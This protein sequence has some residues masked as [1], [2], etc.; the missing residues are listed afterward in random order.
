MLT[1]FEPALQRAVME[2]IASA[3]RPGGALLIGSQESLP[4]ARLDIAR[5]PGSRCIY[6]KLSPGEVNHTVTPD[7]DRLA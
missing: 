1:Y 6:R 2:R 7:E 4:N 5:W 3:L